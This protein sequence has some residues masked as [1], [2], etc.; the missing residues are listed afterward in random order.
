MSITSRTTTCSGTISN[1]ANGANGF[2]DR[3]PFSIL[4]QS[5]AIRIIILDIIGSLPYGPTTSSQPRARSSAFKC[6]DGG[7]AAPEIWRRALWAKGRNA[8]RLVERREAQRPAG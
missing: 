2:M 6:G 1:H 3:A 5:H 8:R 7:E 4:F